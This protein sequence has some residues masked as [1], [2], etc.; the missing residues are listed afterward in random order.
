MS[1]LL[2][3]QQ[4]VSNEAEEMEQYLWQA[5]TAAFIYAGQSCDFPV[6]EM[7]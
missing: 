7:G 6:V 2:P 4:G 1:F 3:H 5:P